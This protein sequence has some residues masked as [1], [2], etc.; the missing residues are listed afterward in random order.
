[1][2]SLPTLRPIERIPSVVSPLDDCAWWLGQA[3][4]RRA[5]RNEVQHAR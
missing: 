5:Q 3:A 4:Q 2:Q 1:M